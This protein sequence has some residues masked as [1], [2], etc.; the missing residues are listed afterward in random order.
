MA[1]NVRTYGLS[2]NIVHV[3]GTVGLGAKSLRENKCVI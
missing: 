2:A 1:S 3:G